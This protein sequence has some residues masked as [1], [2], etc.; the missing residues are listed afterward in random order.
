VWGG[1]HLVL[2]L[3]KENHPENHK[4]EQKKPAPLKKKKKKKKQVMFSKE[5]LTYSRESIRL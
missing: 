2:S 1:R 3:K 4:K 5:C